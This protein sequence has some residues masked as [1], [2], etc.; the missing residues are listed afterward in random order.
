MSRNAKLILLILGLFVVA[1]MIWNS[2]SGTDITSS[3]ISCRL[4]LNGKSAHLYSYDPASFN[5]VSDRLWLQIASA[6]GIAPQVLLSPFVQTPLWPYVLQPLCNGMSFPAFNRFFEIVLVVCF[7]AMIWLTGR[8]WAPRFFTPMWVLAMCILWI[9]ADPLRDA[10]ELNNTHA[11]FLVLTLLAILWA[12]SGRPVLAGA[13]LAIAAAVKITPAVFVIYWLVTKQKK[14]ALSFI[15]WSGALFAITLATS[16]SAIMLD[17]IHSMSR[18][19]HILLLSEG[20]QSLAAWWM[21]YR[22][23]AASMMGFRSLPMPAAMSMI[24]SVFVVLSAVLG[25]YCDLRTSALNSKLPQYGAVITLIGATIFSPIAWGHY[26]ILLVIPMVLLLD[27]CLEKFSIATV[28]I[29]AS[30]FLLAN[31]K[32]LLRQLRYFHV[33]NVHVERGQFYAG[34]IAIIGMFLLYRRSIETMHSAEGPVS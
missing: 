6:K 34:L 16:G 1:A 27:D 25:G 2:S 26:Y 29:F 7:A 11:I 23:P 10:I 30:I 5:L 4:V 20:N 22:Y 28:A 9:K 13:S 21:G 3:Y 15:L 24:S 14:A 18:V 12:R 19:S 33:S 31:T 17:Y 32:V 8:N